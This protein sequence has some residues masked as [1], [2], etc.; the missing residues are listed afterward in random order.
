MECPGCDRNLILW[1]NG[2][3]PD[4]TQTPG[5]K[6]DKRLRVGDFVAVAGEPEA[7]GTI[8]LEFERGERWFTVRMDAD[9]E[10]SDFPED[11]LV[12]AQMATA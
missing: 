2:L 12:G 1:S 6:H 10:F 4:C 11:V 8:A 5:H 9:G 7:T 3:C